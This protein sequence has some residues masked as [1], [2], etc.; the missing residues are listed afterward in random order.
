MRLSE[1]QREHL[2]PS[3]TELYRPE[4]LIH[5]THQG[6]AVRSKSE[7]IVAETLER[8]GLTF[9]YEKP[10]HS[11]SDPRSFRLPDFT[12]YSQGE[13]FY[14]EH[15]GMAG[16]PA[17]DQAW[18]RKLAWYQAN[19]FADQLVTSSDKPDGGI[20]VPLIEKIARQRILES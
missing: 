8:L 11:P 6:V 17:Y 20:D 2:R 5:R 18:E 4:G 13:E 1:P 7:V 14:W 3:A 16:V 9:S 10:L 15:L 19:G 12:V